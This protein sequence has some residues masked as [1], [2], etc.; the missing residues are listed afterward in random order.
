MANQ[1]PPHPAARAECTLPLVGETPLTAKVRRGC[2]LEEREEAH[3]E[4]A[5]H[6]KE[7]SGAEQD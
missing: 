4:S 7:D 2:K 6:A 3:E 5:M 1:P